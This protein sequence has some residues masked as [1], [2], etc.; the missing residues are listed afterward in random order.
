MLVDKLKELDL[1][2]IT[3]L[4]EIMEVDSDWFSNI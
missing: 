2:V 1:G 3:K 4:V